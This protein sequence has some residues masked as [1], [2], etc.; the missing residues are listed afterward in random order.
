[1]FGLNEHEMVA[2]IRESAHC[3]IGGAIFEHIHD[4]Y[5]KYII[6][7]IETVDKEN[8]RLQEKFHALEEYLKIEYIDSRT[9]EWSNRYVKK[10][11]GK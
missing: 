9:I 3:G 5:M 4:F 2:K 6:P 7:K 1:M 11:N 8:V 10:T